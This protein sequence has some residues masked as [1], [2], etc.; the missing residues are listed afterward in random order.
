MGFKLAVVM[1]A[2]IDVAPHW[3]CCKQASYSA[4]QD[5]EEPTSMALDKQTS[6]RCLA[7]PR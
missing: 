2:P 6:A 1:G 3:D 7:D 4:L 5:Y